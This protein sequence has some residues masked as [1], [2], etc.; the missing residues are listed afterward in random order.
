[1][2]N[3][4]TKSG[5]ISVEHIWNPPFSICLSLTVHWMV[6]S[7]VSTSEV[8]IIF[9]LESL[10]TDLE[11]TKIGRSPVAWVSYLVSQKYRHVKLVNNFQDSEGK[12]NWTKMWYGKLWVFCF[13]VFSF[14]K[15]LSSGLVHTFFHLCYCFSLFRDS[16][17]HI[18]FFLLLQALHFRSCVWCVSH[19]CIHAVMFW[20]CEIFR[21]DISK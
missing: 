8:H 19:R 18:V 5:I 20:Q 7:I 3:K 11:I 2:R 4:E 21:S 14:H 9:K 12:M 17:R 13:N 6:D 1:M 10:I 16:Y 15:V